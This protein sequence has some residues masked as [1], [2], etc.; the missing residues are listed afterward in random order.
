VFGLALAQHNMT[1][2]MARPSQGTNG[3]T[4]DQ[5]DMLARLHVLISTFHL[6]QIKL[7]LAPHLIKLDLIFSSYPIKPD[8]LT[9]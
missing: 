9:K 6:N 8:D 5:H 7:I 1:W 2:P 4:L 3:A